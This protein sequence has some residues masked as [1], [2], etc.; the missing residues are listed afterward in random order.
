M[1]CTSTKEENKK[2]IEWRIEIGIRDSRVEGSPVSQRPSIN[3]RTC[4]G[5]HNR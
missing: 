1:S 4:C 3:C 5:S 2:E